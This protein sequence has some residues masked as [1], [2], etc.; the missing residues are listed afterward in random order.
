[1]TC[2]LSSLIRVTAR[3]TTGV[4]S[5]VRRRLPAVALVAL[6]LTPLTAEARQKNQIRFP[7]NDRISLSIQYRN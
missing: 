3:V 6:M 2:P 1:M 4:T 5:G 7:T